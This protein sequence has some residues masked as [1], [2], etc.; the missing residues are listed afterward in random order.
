M[1]YE[2]P[3]PKVVGRELLHSSYVQ[4]HRD[5]LELHDKSLYHY[6]TISTTPCAVM[7]IP[8]TPSGAFVLNEEY[9]HATGQIILGSP[10]GVLDENEDPAEGARREL[11]EETGYD[12]ESFTLL[13]SSFPLPGLSNQRHF[14]VHANNVHYI[15]PPQLERAEILRTVILTPDE[16]FAKMRQGEAIDGTL[17]SAILFYL[18]SKNLKHS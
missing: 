18:A 11:I 9:R 8:T 5:C 3:I 2:L 4:V 12:G 16:I 15:K 13:G 6:T 17:C 1:K 14:Y 10:G 7:V